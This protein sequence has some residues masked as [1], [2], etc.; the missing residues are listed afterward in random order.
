MRK[1]L[2]VLLC[3]AILLSYL[4]ATA[5]PEFTDYMAEITEKDGKSGNC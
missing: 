1:L 2:S 4:P 5:S 3:L